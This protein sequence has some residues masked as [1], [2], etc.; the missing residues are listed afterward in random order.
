LN[1]FRSRRCPAAEY[2]DFFLEEAD[3]HKLDWRLL[4]SLAFVETGGGRRVR[5]ENNWFGWNSG[6][7]RFR[8]VE[9]A[10]HTVAVQLSESG[11][12]RGK[13]LAAV[14]RTYNHRPSYPS[15]IRKV[16]ALIGP[17]VL[18]NKHENGNK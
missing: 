5:C 9:D 2:T 4:P 17:K 18:E 12:Y 3:N 15:R 16:M 13:S 11:L 8:M 14:L 6:Q 7:A 10:I 1:F